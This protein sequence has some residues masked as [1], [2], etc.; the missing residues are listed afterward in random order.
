MTSELFSDV[1]GPA[2]RKPR[3]VNKVA[4][5]E[6]LSEAAASAEAPGPAAAPEPAGQDV[7]PLVDTTSL[8]PAVIFSS[9]ETAD[10]LLDRV[11]ARV[12]MLMLVTADNLVQM[13]FGWEGVGLA[14]Y[15]LI[16]FWFK[17]PSANAAAIKALAFKVTRTRT[18]LDAMGKGLTAEWKEKAKAVDVERARIWDKLA[19]IGEEARAPLTAWEAADAARVQRIQ[20]R[21]Q[22]MR[23]AGAA[24]WGGTSAELQAA[25]DEIQAIPMDETW[26]ELQA[27]AA[28]AKD[29]TLTALH[30]K[31]RAAEEVEAAERARLA[32]E[33]EEAAAR[34]REAEAARQ[35]EAAAQRE[36]E[37][38]EAERQR[39][40]EAV[41]AERERKAAE[42]AKAR[43]AQAEIDK[44]ERE[45]LAAITAE[46]QRR[47]ADERARVAALRHAEEAEAEAERRAAAA[48]EAERRRVAAE[49]AERKRVAEEDRLREEARSA[50][51]EHRR[52]INRKIVDALTEFGEVTTSKGARNSF[53]VTLDGELVWSGLTKGPPRTEKWAK[54]GIVEAVRAAVADK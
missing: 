52:E 26:E 37:A 20:D 32:R 11:R 23:A 4:E 46:T 29:Q 38:A 40:A 30:G 24:A 2:G 18:T 54:D 6:P 45:A 49:E 7:A 1:T 9:P 35:A 27:A 5:A 41:Q 43:A 15:L 33:A 31:R 16:G 3:K 8:V 12:A 48:V 13:F 25:A 34:E 42:E 47:E 44:R 53:E 17:K 10:E 51:R 39:E 21:I 50:N 22:A 19:A 14:S 28:L 36:R